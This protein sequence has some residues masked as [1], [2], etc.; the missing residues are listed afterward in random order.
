[1]RNYFSKSKSLL[2]LSFLLLGVQSASAEKGSNLRAYR[3]HNFKKTES[4]L[5]SSTPSQTLLDKTETLKKQM[6]L[7]NDDQ[8]VPYRSEQKKPGFRHSKMN[9]R[10]KNIPIFGAEVILNETLSS[11]TVR[12]NTMITTKMK[13]P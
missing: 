9:Q 4:S 7:S 11:N 6:T 3:A 12:A 1:M 2:T 13:R 5:S 10:Y 8:L